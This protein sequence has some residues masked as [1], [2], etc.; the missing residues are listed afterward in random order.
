VPSHD[1][2]SNTWKAAK[3]QVIAC[4]MLTASMESDILSKILSREKETKKSLECALYSFVV[5]SHDVVNATS[6]PRRS[7]TK[8]MHAPC[9]SSSMESDVLSEILSPAY[10]KRVAKRS[11]PTSPGIRTQMN[12]F[13]RVQSS[14]IEGSSRPPIVIT[15]TRMA[16]AGGPVRG[17]WLRENPSRFACLSQMNLEY[18]SITKFELRPPPKT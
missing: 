3:R 16:I 6:R 11:G 15:E 12:I 8:R 9:S 5:L 4:A 13:V 7:S 18:E 14:S 2:V 17:E 1:V 10:S